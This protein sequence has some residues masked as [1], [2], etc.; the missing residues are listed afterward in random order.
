MS[1]L[2]ADQLAQIETAL[3]EQQKIVA[4]RLY[5]EATGASLHAAIQFLES[6]FG[7]LTEPAPAGPVAAPLAAPP[8][9]AAAPTTATTLYLL[10]EP[11]FGTHF[12][13]L[14]QELSSERW[15]ALCARAPEEADEAAC[16]AAGES[17]LL[18]AAAGLVLW[19]CCRQDCGTSWINSNSTDTFFADLEA[20]PPAWQGLSPAAAR[21]WEAWIALGGVS[22]PRG[23]P[24]PWWLEGARQVRDATAGLARPESVALIHRHAGEIRALFAQKPAAAD[25]DAFLHLLAEGAARGA[26]ALAWEPGT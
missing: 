1:S 12:R 4:V 7:T 25:A 18:T 5:R 23:E 8:P 10:D 19:E 6:R 24:L 9:A 3:R 11:C 2:T 26:S 14:P 16:A 15:R 17:V 22:G 20:Q 13:S 21:A